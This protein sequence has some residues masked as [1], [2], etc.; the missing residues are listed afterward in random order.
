MGIVY[1]NSVNTGAPQQKINLLLA[2]FPDNHRCLGL[3]LRTVYPT[4]FGH[5]YAGIATLTPKLLATSVLQS[6]DLQYGPNFEK[7]AYPAVPGAELRNIHRAVEQSELPNTIPT[8][9]AIDTTANVSLDF[10]VPMGTRDLTSGYI[11]APGASQMKGVNL[12]FQEGAALAAGSSTNNAIRAAGNV[13]FNVYAITAP[14]TLN[15]YAPMLTYGKGNG[16]GLEADLNPSGILLLAW[17]I[18]AAYG[19][20]S[21]L[22]GTTGANLVT[23]I[24]GGYVLQQSV[25][26]SAVDD[27]YLLN[28]VSGSVAIDD[29]VTIIFSPMRGQAVGDLPC[30]KGKVRQESAYVAQLQPRFLYWPDVTP[31]DGNNSAVASAADTGQATLTTTAPQYIDNG[32]VPPHQLST[33]PLS[34]IPAT[35][36][37]FSLRTGV[38]AKP[39]AQT[40]TASIP[41]GML[42]QA[43]AAIASAGKG[44][45]NSAS[46]AA[47]KQ[48][49][50]IAR[51]MPGASATLGGSKPMQPK[52]DLASVLGAINAHPVSNNGSLAKRTLSLLGKAA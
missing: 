38:I 29:E 42:H 23:V 30:G 34:N 14:D 22:A 51:Q 4:T 5:T 20:S 19:S 17:D 9:A 47:T 50:V 6:F 11:R 2:N 26:M 10:Y 13:Q 32:I 36:P 8:A 35:H 25:P 31:T 39:G 24:V 7:Q 28:W 21:S 18:N 27:Q 45:S 3:L 46:A 1:L 37:S 52:L 48:A 43:S 15:T 44:G 40:T 41:S 49:Q 33:A 12:N 16:Y